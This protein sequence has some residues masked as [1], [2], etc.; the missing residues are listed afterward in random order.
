MF[1]SVTIVTSTLLLC[2]AATAQKPTTGEQKRTIDAAREVA[3][4]YNSTLP[5]FICTEQVQ[6][7]RR[8][9]VRDTVSNDRLTIQL[10]YF[11]RK[12]NYKVLAIDGEP[13]QQ[14][15]EGLSGILTGGEFGSQ[16][17][18]IFDPTSVA[19]FRWKQ[20]VMFGNR[21]ASVYAYRI[22]RAGSHYTWAMRLST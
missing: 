18:G 3:I 5:D 10:T 19:D 14:S 4:R 21:A 20:A 13:A 9:L 17:V 1:R 16:L 6:R 15:L 12:E 8:G 11:G 2:A 22:Q 7:T